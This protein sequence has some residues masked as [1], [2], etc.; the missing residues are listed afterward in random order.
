MGRVIPRMSRTFAPY[1]DEG[2]PVIGKLHRERKQ[3]KH[4]NFSRSFYKFCCGTSLYETLGLEQAVKL[5]L[6]PPKEAIGAV[7]SG[8]R[9][10]PAYLDADLAWPKFVRYKPR[11]RDI[12]MFA[13]KKALSFTYKHFA[14]HLY[15]CKPIRI[16]KLKDHLLKHADLS[17]SAGFPFPGMDSKQT[18]VETMFPFYEKFFQCTQSSVPATV[19]NVFIKEELREIEKV[20]NPSSR[21]IFGTSACQFLMGYQ[22]F[23]NIQQRFIEER[24]NFWSSAGMD[25]AGSEYGRRISK[26]F[27]RKVNSVDGNQFDSNMQEQDILDIH[28]LLVHCM[29]D[30][31]PWFSSLLQTY[32]SNTVYSVCV[33][34]DGRVV[35]KLCGNPSGGFLTLLM[36]TMHNYR[37]YAYVWIKARMD[38]GL[39]IEYKNF[40]SMHEALMNGDDCMITSSESMNWFF[41]NKYMSEF[42]GLST[43]KVG[44]STEIDVE[45]SIYCGCT[46][47]NIDR[48]IVPIRD[49]YK[50]L[51][52]LLF[53]GVAGKLEERLNGIV[54]A[55]IWDD[56]LLRICMK[57]ADLKGYRFP[58]VPAIRHNYI[59][60]EVACVKNSPPK[61]YKN[62][63]RSKL[64]HREQL[65][66]VNRLKERK[67]KRR[68]RERRRSPTSNK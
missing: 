10:A 57:F 14:Q 47:L 52:S 20:I 54:I 63:C 39:D 12:D 37:L 36:N 60:K 38:Q 45:D 42:L 49:S 59:S 40:D 8:L 67:V 44:E 26:F 66:G 58:F 56:S 35:V 6:L 25:F 11:E 34:P 48:A 24:Q 43:I 23:Y 41:I 50:L 64:Y 29:I 22:L 9:F 17:G 61:K 4:F 30:L 13:W 46:P 28:E 1:L 21:I 32:L 18:F 19:W 53:K 2:F 16:E 15:G 7:S 5:N 3:K 31:E 65:I 68:W 55:N 51:L 62:K 33:L 27:G